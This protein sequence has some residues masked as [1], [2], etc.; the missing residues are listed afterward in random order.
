MLSTNGL[1]FLF[2]IDNSCCFYAKHANQICTDAVSNGCNK[3]MAE[4]VSDEAGAPTNEYSK[5]V[6]KEVRLCAS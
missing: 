6:K 5:L 2:V 1:G 4:N 3:R